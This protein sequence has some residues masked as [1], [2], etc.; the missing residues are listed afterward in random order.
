MASRKLPT[1]WMRCL[2]SRYPTV[3]GFLKLR[4]DVI[5][6]GATSEGAPV[7]AAMRAL[8][9]VLAYRS[10]LS[11]APGGGGSPLMTNGAVRVQ[12]GLSLVARSSMAR[13]ASR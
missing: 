1:D 9:G 12:A 3:S 5:S 11:A 7:L 4:P 10:R 8:P 13:A 2:L 6:F